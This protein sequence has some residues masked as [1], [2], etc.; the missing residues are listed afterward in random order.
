MTMTFLDPYFWLNFFY[1]LL[2]IFLAFY[3]PG[4]VFIKQLSLS[5][6]QKIVLALILGMV[7]W[8]I[9]GYI[10]GYIQMRYLSYLYI[11]IFFLLW[12]KSVW[13]F[14]E[15]VTVLFKIPKHIDYV[16][17]LIFLI[18]VSI[19][20]ISVGFNGAF[21]GNSL[22]FCCNVP[23]SLYHIALVDA[24]VKNFPPF[25]PGMTGQVV[26]NYHYLGNLCVA[27]L[28]RVFHL[29]LLYTQNQYLTLFLGILIGLSAVVFAQIAKLKELYI[30]WLV[31]FLY[32][33]G[34]IIYLISFLLGKGFNFNYTLQENAATL[35]SSPPRV[36][37]LVIFFAGL[38]LLRIWLEKKSL[39]IGML[40]AILFG[41]LIGFKV[42]IGIFVLS[43]LGFLGLYF[44]YKRA[45]R[46]L[47]P[48][49]S[50]VFISL[51]LYLPTNSGAGGLFF[52]GLWRLEDFIVNPAYDL[53]RLELARRIYLDHQSWLRVAQYEIIYALLY[54]P[55]LLGIFL[56]GFF[57]TRKSLAVIPF[58]IHLVLL[59]GVLVSTILG[60][61][62]LQE[63]GGANTSQ[64]LFP[65]Y[66]V[67]GIYTALTCS[68]FLPKLKKPLQIAIIIIILLLTVMRVLYTTAKT[69]VYIKN[70]T[71]ISLQADER[72]AIQYLN[73]QPTTSS[74][75]FVGNKK[76]IV[77][78]HMYYL[79]FLVNKPIFLLGNGILTDHGISTEKRV[80]ISD[81]ILLEKKAFTVGKTLRDNK[82][83]YLYMKDG[84]SLISTN[85]AYFLRPVLKNDT[86]MILQVEKD[87][88]DEYIENKVK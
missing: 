29:P 10:V 3:I 85:S 21:Y 55:S 16:L 35:W 26:R 65:L 61:F 70:D 12:S 86:I 88:L 15:Q 51:V 60:V 71:H 72:A 76:D 77:A 44:L 13:Q 34:D 17:V 24:L 18:G 8:T 64:F 74:Y 50:T 31:F 11:L 39:F 73:E 63:T 56:L 7:L 27:E 9:Q 22:H 48:L 43:G 40:M 79:S 82:I 78:N 62:F 75:L 42:Y 47:P 84:S 33:Y 4:I 37:A 14:K 68:Y 87:K 30:R 36:F 20:F 81:A 66:I 2:A 41:V 46:M 32:F 67:G 58:Q 19:Q 28:V 59:S 49:V 5:F 80:N 23:D 54:I 52:G 69:Y 45:F 6:F 83:E 38:T 25:E 1:F 53:S 57:Q